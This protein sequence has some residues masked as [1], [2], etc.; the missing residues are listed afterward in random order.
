MY[1]KFNY[2]MNDDDY[3]DFDVFIQTN[4][5]E[6]KLRTKKT[7]INTALTCITL[8]FL[9]YLMMKSLEF[10]A[11]LFVVYLIWFIVKFSCKKQNAVRN[12]KRAMKFHEKTG[13]KL[14]APSAVMEFTDESFIETTDG[15]RT[16]VLYSVVKKM[17]VLNGK[18]VLIDINRSEYF[19]VP[20]KSFSSNE[21]C[22]AFIDFLRT[23]IQNVEFY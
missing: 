12:T 3:V 6:G 15:I 23:K 19:I 4:T 11:V 22:T 20:F 17:S 16:E 7:M 1:F 5:E 2:T 13:K 8:C 10:L 21:E 9:F 14:Y 18:F